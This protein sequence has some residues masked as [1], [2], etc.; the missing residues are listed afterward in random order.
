MAESSRVVTPRRLIL[1]G[2][3]LSVVLVVAAVT[4]SLLPG[5]PRTAAG[6]SA[7]PSPA[8]AGSADPGAIGPVIPS[9]NAAPDGT[10]S[11]LSPATPRPVGPRTT[12]EVPLGTVPLAAVPIATLPP[13]TA[14][15]PLVSGPLPASATS[16]GALVAGFPSAI[17]LPAGNTITTS[18]VSSNGNR[19]QAALSAKTTIGS[20]ELVDWYTAQFAK[21]SLPGSPAPAVGGSTAFAFALGDD[22]ITLTVTSAK[23]GGSRY[24]LLGTFAAVSG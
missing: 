21:L 5:A 16:T 19:L 1:A 20:A 23:A 7:S 9:T 14:V 17:P 13:S 15:G 4:A 12:T 3:G 8:A 10:P 6:T 18:S 2:V 22:S 11:T 24:T